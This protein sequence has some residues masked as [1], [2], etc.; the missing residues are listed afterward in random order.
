MTQ[1]P[2]DPDGADD[3]DGADRAG[4]AG[5]AGGPAVGA[6][7]TYD[8]ISADYDAA[9]ADEL[10]SKPL[11]RALLT[12]FVEQVGPGVSCDVGCGPGHVTRFLAEHGAQAIGLDI[13]AAMIERAR[14]RA[15]ALTFTTGSML[16]LPVADGAWAGIVCLYSVIHLTPSERAT[17]WAE[18]ARA[19]RPGGRLLLA[20]HVASPDYPMGSVNHL[21]TWFGKRVE[22]D[23]Y[24]L[25]P[26]EITAQLTAAGFSIEAR[27]DRSPIEGVEYPSHRC[28]LIA[29]RDD[30]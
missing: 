10:D 19:I 6:A 4:G 15:P 7:A 1:S 3:A 12:S 17:A 29:R 9:F 30:R 21:T 11:D 18:F 2:G 14:R 5:G 24:F 22:L 28:Y 13:S 16:S 25:D 20:F 26:D 27:L 23:G 8:A